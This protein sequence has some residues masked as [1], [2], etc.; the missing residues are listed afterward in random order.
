MNKILISASVLALAS[1]SIMT[2][3]DNTPELRVYLPAEMHIQSSILELGSVCVL[4]CDDENLAA[5]ASSVALGRAPWTKEAMVI[6]RQT[7]LARLATC[8]IPAAQVKISGAEKV[9]ILRDERTVSSDEILKAAEEFLQKSRPGPEGCMW[10]LANKIEDV[11]VPEAKDLRIQPRLAKDSPRDSVKLQIAFL[12]GK[13]ELAATE[14]TFKILYVSQQAVAVKD[15]PAGTLLTRDNIKVEK[16][17]SESKPV[18]GWTPPYGMVAGKPVASGTVLAGNIIQP[19]KPEILV[20]RNQNVTMRIE[21]KGFVVTAM[22]EA[23]ED[24]RGGDYI[25]VRNA[26]TKRV[27]VAKVAF[28]GSV[29]P[30]MGEMKK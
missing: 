20:K 11:V 25:K 29:E 14:A 3:A 9:T 5:K 1:W 13:T 24:G 7:I 28:D 8:G 27:I 12:S 6:D 22:G 21:G 17:P 26:D 16:V 2:A 30:T 15:I 18:E 10:K 23:L 4:R 19:P